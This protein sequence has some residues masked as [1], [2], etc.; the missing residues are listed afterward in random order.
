M[1][2][3]ANPIP[4]I[5]PDQAKAAGA[6]IIGTGRSDFKNQINN[7]L[8]F[9]GLFRGCLDIQAKKVTVEMKIAAAKGLAN[10]VSDDELN[11]DH[12]IPG[13]LDLRVPQL[14][15]KAVAEAG[16]ACGIAQN[17]IEP[18]LVQEKIRSFLIEGVLRT[19]EV[20]KKL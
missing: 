14:V 17:K 19:Y 18:L 6:F 7:S 20:N 11:S 8:A 2:A 10:L 9:P 13:A 15:A 12:I 5:L 4:E 1:F 16:L 3:L